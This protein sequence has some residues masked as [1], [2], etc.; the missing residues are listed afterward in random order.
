MKRF[1]TITLLLFVVSCLILSASFRVNAESS[2]SV[3][4]SRENTAAN[5]LSRFFFFPSDD[6]NDTR[7]SIKAWRGNWSKS[8]EYR[9]GDVVSYMGSA[10]ISVSDRRHT[11]SLPS[12]TNV[13]WNLMV[14]KGD[15]G[16]KG[17][18]GDAGDKG[19]LGMQGTAGRDGTHGRQGVT[20]TDGLPGLAGSPGET[21]DIGRPG[22]PGNNG[23]PGIKGVR[24]NSGA[25]GPNGSNGSRGE[26]GDTGAY[27]AFPRFV[28]GAGTE[29]VELPCASRK[30]TVNGM[31]FTGTI[32]FP[33]AATCPH[34][35]FQIIATGA[36]V[37]VGRSASC[38]SPAC[39]DKLKLSS[40]VASVQDITSTFFGLS[41]W[42][43]DASGVWFMLGN[44]REI[45]N[46]APTT[47]QNIKI[48]P[49]A[50]I[51]GQV[52]ITFD[53][54]LTSLPIT[55]TISSANGIFLGS[56][57]D[58]TV[59]LNDI[60]LESNYNLILQ[61]SNA[62]GTSAVAAIQLKL[63]SKLVISMVSIR[64]SN[65]AAY[66][67]FNS[68]NYPINLRSHAVK[69][70]TT[71]L[72]T[73][74]L[75]NF[76]LMSGQYYLISRRRSIDGLVPDLVYPVG[77]QA[78]Q[79]IQLLYGASF[80]RIDTIAIG[81]GGSVEGEALFIAT[82]PGYF[83]RKLDGCQDTNKNVVDFI[84]GPTP[85]RPLRNSNSPVQMCP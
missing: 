61:A 59:I 40:D 45:V 43:N 11:N 12:L 46:I 81:I 32:R 34:V 47:P 30:V 78:Q 15:M 2:S 31:I 62:V 71:N 44:A 35:R 48:V 38:L 20:G 29:N 67:L 55:Y 25:A 7:Q 36:S 51:V 53:L 28:I 77:S 37:R 49:S 33:I 83:T 74:V 76:V 5:R 58:S 8:E 14:R 19:A 27:V 42:D 56:A 26:P 50:T 70:I 84:F 69:I 24:G 22:A 39:N 41:I 73:F 60:E 72:I 65:D 75:D 57:V 1:A 85:V 9:A 63:P 54:Q 80:Q 10:W 21:G 3:D 16:A 52:A 23:L 82:L 79:E 68:G 6:D 4:S 13:K 64:S 66:E 17:A 18:K